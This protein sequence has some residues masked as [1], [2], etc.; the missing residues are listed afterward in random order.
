[1]SE[2]RKKILDMVGSGQ[3][4]PEEGSALLK[5]VAEPGEEATT[6]A[7]SGEEA[8]T[9]A[10]P[11]QVPPVRETRS[12]VGRELARPFWLYPLGAG[13]VVLLV[14]STVLLTMHQ[15]QRANVWTWLCGWIPLLVGL[16]IVTV[17]AWARTAHWVH[18]RVRDHGKRIAMSL[19]LPLG[20]AALAM[21]VARPFVPQLRDTSVDEAIL[22]LREELQG[23]EDITIDVQ[24]DDEGE[25]VQILFGGKP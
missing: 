18:L 22:T 9:Q 15:Q 7:E 16:T 2:E 13:L 5:L 17:A 19:P 23:N 3:I 12:P 1:M 24:D 14:G 21:R 11:E 10:E 20:L 4:S 8:T 6:Q 25:S